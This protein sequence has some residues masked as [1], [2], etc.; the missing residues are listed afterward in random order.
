MKKVIAT[1]L[2]LILVALL[3][4]SFLM[5]KLITELDSQRNSQKDAKQE[6]SKDV[7]DTISDIKE[8]TNSVVSGNE[9]SGQEG[10]KPTGGSGS[11]AIGTKATPKVTPTPVPTLSPS[12]VKLAGGSVSGKLCYPSEFLPAMKVYLQEVTKK[13]YLSLNTAQNSGTYMFKDVP[14]GT[15]IAFAWLPD[16]GMGGS[17]SQAVPCGLTVTCNDHSPIQV[18]VEA[19]KGVTGVDICDWYSEKDVPAM[20]K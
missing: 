13:T 3:V 16:G 17:Y 14:A 6:A 11:S 19:G 12:V 9:E 8:S 5:Y 1:L 10:Q 20:P 7:S 4:I 18:K 15:Y 2:S